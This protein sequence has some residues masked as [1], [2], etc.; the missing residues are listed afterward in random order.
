MANEAGISLGQTWDLNLIIFCEFLI[1]NK[2]G[3]QF[4]YCKV[5]SLEIKTNVAR[6]QITK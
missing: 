2:E 4:V 3:N 5:S 6:T 1:L